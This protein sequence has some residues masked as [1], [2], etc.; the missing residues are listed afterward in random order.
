VAWNNRFN[1]ERARL[2]ETL[3]AWIDSTGDEFSLPEL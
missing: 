3:A 1:A 2:Q